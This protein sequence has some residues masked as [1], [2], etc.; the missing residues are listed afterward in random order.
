M[1]DIR[2]KLIQ[3]NQKW[4]S[5]R[6]KV[7]AIEDFF[8]QNN[9]NPNLNLIIDIG[10]TNFK[11]I[12]FENT[13]ALTGP[14]NDPTVVPIV[15]NSWRNIN[16]LPL[17]AGYD[18]YV[19]HISKEDIGDRPTSTAIRGD[20]DEV[21]VEIIYFGGSETD[22]AYVN[23]KNMGNA[24]EYFV[25]HEL[26]HA[27]YLICDLDDKTHKYF[28]AGTPELVLADFTESA[29]TLSVPRRLIKF[30]KRLIGIYQ[31]NPEL[32]SE[33]HEVVPVIAPETSKTALYDWSTPEKARHSVRVICDEEGLL[34]ND[35]N[36]LCAT[37]GAE[38]G[39]KPRQRSLKPNF[40]GTYDHGIVQLNEKYWIG[41]G[42]LYPNIEAVYNDPEG[43]I[44]WMC[45]QWKLGN[46]NWWYAFK[47]RSYMR[48]M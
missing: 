44:R 20:M 40:D 43:C 21:P 45:K 39:W 29:L 2:V 36:E 37:V 1:R 27:L 16:L 3:N 46:K 42:K 10:F 25:K 23:G 47:N 26:S 8:N 35:K 38:S 12:P 19:F 41:E 34:W 48:F 13:P 17:C 31:K 15:S 6:Q 9:E 7:E 32:I 22:E 11:D 14:N 30:L 33:V 18:A 24:Y 28:Y 4:T 5:L